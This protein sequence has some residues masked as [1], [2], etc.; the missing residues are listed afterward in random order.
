MQLRSIGFNDR[1]DM[2]AL[3]FGVPGNTKIFL[4]QEVVDLRKGFEGLGGLIRTL[5]SEEITSGAYFVFLNRERNRIKVLYWDLDGLAIWYKRL[6]KGRFKRSTFGQ[7]LIDRREFFMMLEGVT[8]KRLQARFR[9][10]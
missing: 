10:S 4:C 1:T 6:E 5:F 8:P 7:T 3:M 2:E 9:A